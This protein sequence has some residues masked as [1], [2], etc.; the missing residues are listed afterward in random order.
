MT[1]T[2]AKPPVRKQL[3]PRVSVT[4][5]A[6]GNVIR[7]AD[8]AIAIVLARDINARVGH[9]KM[10]KIITVMAVSLI[11]SVGLN[12]YLATRPTM[13]RYFAT[14]NDG[15]LKEMPSLDRPI[16]TLPEVTTWLTNG[17]TQA[18]TLSFANYRDAMNAAS[19]IFTREGWIGFKKALN[20]SG[21]L[22][23]VVENKYVT[24]AV[25]TGAAILL[26]SGL[27]AGRYAW[28]FQI[29]ILVTYQSASQRITQHL[30]VTAIV[31]RQPGTEQPRGLGIASLI[32]E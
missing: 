2:K 16:N 6:S 32:A 31:V 13:L 26:T 24:T 4:T 14:D 7:K 17:I 23:D 10:M 19:V 18:Y 5:V 27:L 9:C 11:A 29:P 25:P 1:I 15:L 21:S 12:C 3:P 22:K 8:E 30:M 20:D 28:K